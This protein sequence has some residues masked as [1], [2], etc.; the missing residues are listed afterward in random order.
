M[1]KRL[2]LDRLESLP[3][4]GPSMADDLRRIGI[5]EPGQLRQAVPEDLFDRLQVI[6]GPTDRCVLYAFRAA[7]HFVQS[8]GDVDDA[9][10][11]DWWNWKDSKRT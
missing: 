4:I 3:G 8:D 6:D 10:L 5:D 11:L 9:E 7:H 1:V 2:G